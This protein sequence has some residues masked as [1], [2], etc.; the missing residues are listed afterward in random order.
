MENNLLCDC[1]MSDEKKCSGCGCTKVSREEEI[2]NGERGLKE[3]FEK[4]GY[5]DKKIAK[6][7]ERYR[8]LMECG[9]DPFFVITEFF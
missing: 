2:K 1:I 7:L 9:V 6:D 4:K 5:N 3:I 8:K